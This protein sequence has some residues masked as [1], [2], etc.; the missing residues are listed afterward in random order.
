[1]PKLVTTFLTIPLAAFLIFAACVGAFIFAFT[2]QYGFDVKPCI[3]CLWQRVPFALAGIAALMAALWE[4]YGK[5]TRLLLFLCALMFFINSGVSVFHTGVERHWWLG[6]SGCAITPLHGSAPEDLRQQ[7]LHTVV[8]R[9]DVISWTFLG[10]SMANWNVPFCLALAV[11]SLLAA[12][13][14]KR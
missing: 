7:L 10:L 14:Q 2:M 9:C 5:Q 6:T 11:F 3:L 12:L 13:Y 8:A 4:P 1:M